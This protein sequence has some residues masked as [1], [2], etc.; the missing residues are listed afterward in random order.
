MAD[1]LKDLLKRSTSSQMLAA[2]IGFPVNHSLSPTIHNAGFKHLDLQWDYIPLEVEERDLEEVFEQMRSSNL[3]GLSVTMPYKAKAAMMVDECTPTAKVLG[4]VNCV[5]STDQGLIGHNT[6]GDGF[7]KALKHDAGFDLKQKRVVVLG[8]GGAAKAITEALGRSEVSSLAVINRTQAKAESTADLA[9]DV[10]SVGE[11]EDISEADLV[12]NA[13]SLGM[14]DNSTDFPCPIDLIHSDQLVVDLIY[15][16]LKTPWLSAAEQ[17]GVRT[18]N[19]VSMLLFQ[20][21][22]A[23]TLW[24]G[25]QAPVSIMLRAIEEELERRSHK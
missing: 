16:P 18:H 11:L 2:V 5:T 6:D 1:N 3:K 23:F 4:A 10:G 12:V 8:A 17:K 9:G 13:T 22:E 14:K 15:H 20:A 21:T 7:L 19:G 25:E 24:T